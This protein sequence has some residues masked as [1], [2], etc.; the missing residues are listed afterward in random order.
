M[1]KNN[2]VDLRNPERCVKEVIASQKTLWYTDI[3]LPSL[4]LRVYPNGVGIW[5]FRRQKEGKMCTVPLGRYGELPAADAR[6]MAFQFQTDWARGVHPK[7]QIQ[8]ASA[9]AYTMAEIFKEYYNGYAIHECG[10]HT[11]MEKDVERYWHLKFELDKS[12]KKTIAELS[13]GELKPIIIQKWMNHIKDNSGAATANKQLSLLRSSYNWC[14]K[15]DLFDAKNEP[16]RDVKNFLEESRQRYLTP[17]EARL[18]REALD[19]NPGLIADCLKIMLF[20]GQRR[21]VCQSMEWSELN[22]ADRVW[23][24]PASKLKSRRSRKGEPLTVVLST[25]AMKVLETRRLDKRPGQKYVFE[26]PSKEG[27]LKN[28]H[29]YLGKILQ[30]TGIEDFRPHDLRH[31]FG[32][33][34]GQNNA[35]AFIIQDA[36]GHSDSKMTKRYTHLAVDNIRDHVEAAFQRQLAV[37]EANVVQFK[38]PD[39]VSEQTV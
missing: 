21:G 24:I 22:L 9:W 26:S 17:E 20:T 16:F 31:T 33:W 11:E 18:F 1:P 25:Y 27:H 2:R 29:K 30:Q 15:K 5:Y 13:P 3:D 8:K 7:E 38:A 34:L 37:P 6:Q 4:T 36:L 35:T 28:V 39:T 32:S 19:K 12:I 14:R 10:T 23:V